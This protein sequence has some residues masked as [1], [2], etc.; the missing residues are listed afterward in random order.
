MCANDPQAAFLGPKIWDKPMSLTALDDSEFS[1]MNIDD[2]LN[3]NNIDLDE[4]NGGA[5]TESASANQ[6]SPAASPGSPLAGAS[7]ASHMDQQRQATKISREH[8]VILFC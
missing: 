2:F 5:P 1:I 3:E 7:P 6:D 4:N 8:Q